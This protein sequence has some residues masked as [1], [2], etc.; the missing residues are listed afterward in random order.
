MK[1]ILAN[2]KTVTVDPN[3]VQSIV[4]T[5]LLPNPYWMYSKLLTEDDVERFLNHDSDPK[6]LEKV[7]YYI[8]CYTENIV[9]I[10]FLYIKAKDPKMA[11]SYL[12]RMK[13]LLRTL[14]KMKDP[15]EMLR[16]CLDWGIDPL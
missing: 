14:R 8:L 4:T 12:K 13:D 1:F 9:F 11:I 7:R 6:L 2:G 15:Y 16:L 3:L 5:Q 10:N